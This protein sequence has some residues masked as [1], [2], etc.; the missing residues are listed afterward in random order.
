MDQDQSEHSGLSFLKIVTKHRHNLKQNQP[1]PLTSTSL[2]KVQLCKSNSPCISILSELHHLLSSSIS[3]FS[4]LFSRYSSTRS[5]KATFWLFYLEDCVSAPLG[6]S[7]AGHCHLHLRTCNGHVLSLWRSYFKW[8]NMTQKLMR[9][10]KHPYL[11]L[12]LIRH[13]SWYTKKHLILN[14]RSL[15]QDIHTHNS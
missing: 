5:T 2:T 8:L 13:D 11:H 1:L 12:V 10:V 3:F 15:K 4:L 9:C 14:L 6:S 7:W